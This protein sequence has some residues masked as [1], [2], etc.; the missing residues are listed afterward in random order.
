MKL[1]ARKYSPEVKSRIMKIFLFIFLPLCLSAQIKPSMDIIAGVE[2]SH[3]SIN[4][5]G[6]AGGP[7]F[8]LGINDY[9]SGALGWRLGVNANLLIGESMFFKMG[10]RYV[11]DKF[12]TNE[13]FGLNSQVFTFSFLELPFAFRYQ[14]DKKTFT[15][16]VEFGINANYHLISFWKDDTGLKTPFEG[17]VKGLN[18]VLAISVG[19]NYSLNDQ[20]DLFVQPVF[21]YHLTPIVTDFFVFTPDEV[22]NLYNFGLELGLR[23]VF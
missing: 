10:L 3:L 5:S 8:T 20:F 22:A 6:D 13:N 11:N 1:A 21:R 7:I 12:K 23:R 14:Y 16:F 19:A 18:L 9:Y 15:P 4:R 2:Y 17:D